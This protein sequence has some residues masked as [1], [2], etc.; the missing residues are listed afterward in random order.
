MPVLELNGKQYAQS[1]A[2]ARYFGRKFGLAGANEEEAL[3]IDSIVEFLNDIQAALVFYETDE[4]LKA[5]K[6]EDFVKNAY[7]EMLNKLASIAEKNN[8]HLALGKTMLQMPD[9]ADTT[10]VFKRIQQSVLSIPKVKK[11]VDQ[12]P[13]SELPF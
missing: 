12:M 11:Y 6:H 4:K 3:E 7:P 13:Q 2:L 8:G 10:P 9:L 5:A 1:I